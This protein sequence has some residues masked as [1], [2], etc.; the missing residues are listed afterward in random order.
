MRR[1]KPVIIGDLLSLFIKNSGLEKGYHDYQV[2]KL[3][4]EILGDVIS[5]ATLDKR[6]DNK[7]LYVYLSSSVIRDELYMMRSEIV[8]EINRRTGENVID[9]I[10][11]R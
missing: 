8:S 5:K 3:W 11:L 6:L 1:C 4:D 2:L 9:E 7:K 10:I